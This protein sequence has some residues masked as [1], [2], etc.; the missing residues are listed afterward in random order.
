[1]SLKPFLKEDAQFDFVLIGNAENVLRNL[2]L[3][4][5]LSGFRVLGIAPPQS[6][7]LRNK[8]LTSTIEID[9]LSTLEFVKNLKSIESFLKKSNA[10]FLWSSD[11]IMKVVAESNLDLYCKK[12]ILPIKNQEFWRIFDSKAAQSQTFYFLGVRQ[13]KTKIYEKA[14]NSITEDW[15]VESRVLLK[16]NSSGGGAFIHE[17]DRVEDIDLEGINSNWFPISVQEFIAGKDLMVEAYFKNGELVL[18]LAS[19]TLAETTKFGP[20]VARRYLDECPIEAVKTLSSL[21]RELKVNGFVNVTFRSCS[22]SEQLYL[23]EFDARPNIWHGVFYE[24]EIPFGEIWV[25]GGELQGKSKIIASDFYDPLRL[26]NWSLEK[27]RI[28][29]AIKAMKGNSSTHFGAPLATEFVFEN[30]GCRGWV[31]ILLAPIYPFRQ[32]ILNKLIRVKSRL[33]QTQREFIDQSNIKRALLR[34]LN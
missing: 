20:S 26:F 28:S 19:E 32:K 27:G 34:I 17:F 31:K 10:C 5:K 7:L 21:G 1:M 15:E 9:G 3:S 11:E 22:Q 33:P 12:N 2:P 13:P 16:G 30:R 25:N 18:A 14:K 23:I 29:E 6:T 8:N 24:L 4:L